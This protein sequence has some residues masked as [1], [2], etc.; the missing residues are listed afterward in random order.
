[1]LLLL[2]PDCDW[3]KVE[4]D[5]DVVGASPGVPPDSVCVFCSLAY[6]RPHACVRYIS[7][8]YIQRNIYHGVICKVA[9]I[10]HG[11]YIN[12]VHTQGV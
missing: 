1:M 4:D 8:L 3:E 9:H 2:V 11:G 7:N 12:D 5:N 10:H 6:M